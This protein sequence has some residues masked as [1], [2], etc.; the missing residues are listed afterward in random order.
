MSESKLF[1]V[2]EDTC[3]RDGLCARSCPGSVIEFIKG[4]YPKISA[5]GESRC[6]SC[7]HCVAVCPSASFSHRDISVEGCTPIDPE[8]DISADQVEQFLTSRRSIRNFTNEPVPRETIE[9]LISVTTYAPSALN[10]RFIEWR[11]VDDRNELRIYSSLSAEW[12]AGLAEREPKR[13]EAL[14]MRTVLA[15]WEKGLDKFLKWAP[16]VVIAHAKK[17][18]PTADGACRNALV[19]LE[20]A[21]HGAGLGACQTGFFN[22]AALSYPP[23]MERLDLPE[24]HS[25]Y[26]SLVL[27]FPELTYPR[28]PKRPRPAITFR[29]R[30]SEIDSRSPQ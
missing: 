9:R 21:A 28:A 5:G 11:V 20:L 15:N 29:S 25:L 17:D 10:R 30:P 8:L 13:F 26:G 1:S 16:A 23:L 18:T 2:D 12:M 3:L 6:I 22:M 4:S 19:Y 14:N 27:G 7:G 24:G